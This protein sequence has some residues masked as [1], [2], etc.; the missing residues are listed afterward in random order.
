MYPTASRIESMTALAGFYCFAATV[1]VGV[2]GAILKGLSA[3]EWIF[4]GG[5]GAAV[6]LW[7][8]S[9]LSFRIQF[10]QISEKT[11][12]W[13][14]AGAT[15]T[16]CV[17]GALL[18]YLL[19]AAVWNTATSQSVAFVDLLSQWDS[20]WYASIVLDGY[21]LR[22]SQSGVT[23]GKANW[24]F[25]PLYPLL[26]WVVKTVSGASVFF[27]GTVVSVFALVLGC[28]FAYRYLVL[29][30]SRQTAWLA[31]GLLAAGPYS[32][33]AYTLYTE[34]LFICLIS[35]AFWALRTDHYLVAATAGGLM[36]ATRSLGVLFGVAML[37]HLILRTDAFEPLRDSLSS[38]VGYDTVI[39]AKNTLF[40]RRVLALGLVPIGLF[41][42]MLYLWWHVGNPLAF[43]TILSEWG[44]SF[45]NPLVKLIETLTYPSVRTYYLGAVGLFALTLAIDLLR[46]E[47]PVEGIF[48]L[49]LLLVPMSSGLTS[50]PRY[51]FGT[52]VLVFALADWLGQTEQ[53]QRIG[54]GFFTAVNAVLIILWYSRHPLLF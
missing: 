3:V 24:A 10:T 30:R 28:T 2:G 20:G 40:D 43:S 27:A 17:G 32:F 5:I 6:C 45:G 13:I 15:A 42:Y 16:V 9:F 37:L 46:R 31:V 51:A 48:A 54:F 49:L 44:R 35:I 53:T 34:A 12:R 52:T 19:A 21:H 39:A 33:Y 18:I 7:T 36:S 47:R 25:F 26:V 1:V 8:V 11:A 4:V 23:A 38:S 14:E 29:T 22:P 50:I 41:S